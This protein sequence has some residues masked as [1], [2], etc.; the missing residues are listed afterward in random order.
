[1]LGKATADGNYVGV[2]PDLGRFIAGRLGVS[3]AAVRYPTPTAFNASI[4]KGEWDVCVAAH[5]APFTDMLDLADFMV[6]EY[7]YAAR[8]GRSFADVASVDRA[9]VKVG[10]P[11]NTPIDAFLSSHLQAAQVVRIQAGEEFAIEALRRGDV[12]VFG[13]N[14][15]ATSEIAKDVAG[16][17]IVPGTFNT[18]AFAFGLPKGRSAA[19]QSRLSGIVNDAVASGLVQRAI[20]A[21]G[22][23]G[24]RVR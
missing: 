17:T 23:I 8:A 11:G 14:G 24:V 3:Y 18:V 13:D 10:V 19:A 1:M 16:A 4:G 6:A 22:L 9:G 12:D 15:L 2:V 5:T 7:R 20:V 21:A